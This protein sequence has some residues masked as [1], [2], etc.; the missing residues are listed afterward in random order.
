MTKILWA[1]EPKPLR[2]QVGKL[3]ELLGEEAEVQYI[4]DSIPAEQ[5]IVSVHRRMPDYIVAAETQFSV[6][7]YGAVRDSF[8]SIQDLSEK[9][10]PFF[11]LEVIPL[12]VLWKYT[13]DGEKSDKTWQGRKLVFVSFLRISAGNIFKWGF[14]KKPQEH[15]ALCG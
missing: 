7:S 1:I 6:I 5:K 14:L 4:G 11:G 2:V 15:F 9:I 10:S 12:I 8:G 3:S 13:L